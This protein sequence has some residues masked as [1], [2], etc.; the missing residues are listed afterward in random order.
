MLSTSS[1]K[2]RTTRYMNRKTSTILF[3]LTYSTLMAKTKFSHHRVILH[4]KIPFLLPPDAT[5][6]V[7]AALENFPAHVHKKTSRR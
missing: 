6:P 5:P 3:V 1:Q 2:C 4:S 7:G